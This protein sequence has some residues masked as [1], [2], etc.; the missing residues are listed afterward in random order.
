[1]YRN[2]CR[3]LLTEGLIRRPSVAVTEGDPLWLGV[4]FH[5]QLSSALVSGDFV[6]SGLSGPQWCQLVL[7][8]ALLVL[9]RVPGDA[10][11]TSCSFLA[12]I[13][14]LEPSLAVLL[15]TWVLGGYGDVFLQYETRGALK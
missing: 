7:C 12:S 8:F 5:A 3:H 6:S 4:M 14:P 10:K 11:Q 1:M 2:A 9:P 13:S 15:P